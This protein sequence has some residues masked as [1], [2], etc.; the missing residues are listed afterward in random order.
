MLSI[1]STVA[2]VL[3]TETQ[4]KVRYSE[5]I[6]SAL[7]SALNKTSQ[8]F[9]FVKHNLFL[10]HFT[11][12]LIPVCAKLLPMLTLNLHTSYCEISV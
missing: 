2:T 10:F 12:L 6:K 4:T 5:E 8:R 11:L 3:G 7:F 9:L 1:C